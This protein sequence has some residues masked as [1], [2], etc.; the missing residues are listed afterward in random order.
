M[1]IMLETVQAAKR[2]DMDVEREVRDPSKGGNGHEA[3]R[4]L[5]GGSFM[6]ET[7][8]KSKAEEGERKAPRSSVKMN[9]RIDVNDTAPVQNKYSTVRE[10]EHEAID[11]HPRRH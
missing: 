4:E 5:A 6:V 11:C 1:V 2:L 7:S 8:V 3:I 9:S 10:V